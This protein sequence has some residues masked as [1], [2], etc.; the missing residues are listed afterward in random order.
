MHAHRPAIRRSSRAL[1]IVAAPSRM[2]ARPPEPG[3]TAERRRR[4]HPPPAAAG[5]RLGVRDE[6]P[7][8]AV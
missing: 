1:A 7:A 5:E 6:R 4:R 3:C 8:A 2:G